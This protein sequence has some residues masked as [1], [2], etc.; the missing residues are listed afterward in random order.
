ME[1]GKLYLLKNSLDR[2]KNLL[3]LKINIMS[4][5]VQR[6]FLV[7]CFLEMKIKTWVMKLKDI[8]WEDNL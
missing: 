1:T 4:W 6:Q 8:S 7:T 3:R 5:Q 2:K